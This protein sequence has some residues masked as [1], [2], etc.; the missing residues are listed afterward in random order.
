MRVHRV[1]LALL[2]LATISFTLYVL[3]SGF[4]YYSMSLL[5]RP[6]DPLH[7][8]LRSSGLMGHWMGIA[9]SLMMLLLLVYFFRKRWK[10]LHGAGD[11]RIWLDYHIWLGITGP[12][13]VILHTA[14]KFKGLVAI[15]FWSMIAVALSGV[16]GRYIYLQIPRAE[17]GEELSEAEMLE[18]E[19]DTRRELAGMLS[20][21]EEGFCAIESLNFVAGS[22]SGLRMLLGMVMQDLRTP[23][24]LISL[25]RRLKTQGYSQSMF[26][27]ALYLHR[28]NVQQRKR[29]FRSTARAYLHHWHVIHR[30]FAAV[31]LVFMFVHVIV[32]L[33]Y[34]TWRIL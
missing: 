13:L 11:I 23:F 9:G 21:H 30:P 25:Y 32:A 18:H 5:D 34:G 8:V 29:F 15:S 14:F 24:I 22:R 10:V 3:I 1:F 7:G 27:V 4:D 17:S 6:R 28:Y 19:A 31:M 20:N 16:L 26:R 2:Y 33:L 12:V